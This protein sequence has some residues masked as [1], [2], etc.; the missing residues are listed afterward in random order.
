M[1]Q[2][3]RPFDTLFDLDRIDVEFLADL[4]RA[5]LA[6]AVRAFE[7]EQLFFEQ[8]AAFL[9]AQLR[10]NSTKFK[11]GALAEGAFC[12]DAEIG[13]DGFPYITGVVADDHVDFEDA[14]A[15]V[16]T[17]EPVGCFYDLFCDW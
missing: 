12:Y 9:A 1:C 7:A 3:N 10:F 8:L 17:A 16:F 15:V 2:K 4:G 13:P 14:A 11:G 5:A 6:A